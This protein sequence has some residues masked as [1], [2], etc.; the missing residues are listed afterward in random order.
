MQRGPTLDGIG[1][2]LRESIEESR[3][4]AVDVAK[5]SRST[6]T[7]VVVSY[8]PVGSEMA[9]RWYVEQALEAGCAFVNCIPVF[10]ASKP[11]WRRRFE[12]AGCR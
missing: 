8:L 7:D 5:R 4:A 11:D 12:R 2:Y 10:I 3:G 1:Q 6:R 9:T